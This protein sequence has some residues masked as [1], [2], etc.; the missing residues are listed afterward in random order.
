MRLSCFGHEARL[1][2][3]MNVDKA[4]RAYWK[5]LWAA[6]KPATTRSSRSGSVNYLEKRFRGFFSEV[7][8]DME[9]SGAKLLEAGC[10][11]STW[12]PYFASEF[13]FAVGGIDYTQSAC[14]QARANLSRQNVPGEI[15]C[16][17]FFDPPE[18]MRQ[19]FDVVFSSGVAEHFTDTAGCLSS[20]TEF[21]KPGG[22]MITSI[23]NMRGLCGFVQKLLNRPTFDIHVALDAETLAAAH[24]RAGLRILRC[25]YFMSTN[26]GVV[27]LNG[28]ATRS[29]IGLLEKITLAGLIRF[30]HLFWIME[31]FVGQVSPNRISSPYI[32]CVARKLEDQN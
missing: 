15:V 26:F 12:L 11:S 13:G 24:E 20:L 10:G 4:G 25:D 5:Q 23:P 28:V 31:D 17:D 21:L 29:P 9:T 30:S 6:Q 14:D 3:A 16:A 22:L 19:A 18:Q 2:E 1:H 7:F 8:A 32:N 27:S